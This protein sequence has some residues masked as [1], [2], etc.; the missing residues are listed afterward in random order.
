M[1]LPPSYDT[2]FYPANI[3]FFQEQSNGSSPSNIIDAR[4]VNKLQNVLAAVE[5]HTQYCTET[6]ISTG[7]TVYFT[8]FQQQLP[9]D[10]P[11]TYMKMSVSIPPGIASSDF[12]GNPFNRANPVFA[13]AVGYRIVGGNRVYFPVHCGVNVL[14]ENNNYTCIVVAGKQS[15]WKAGDWVEGALLVCKT[16]EEEELSP[17]L[18]DMIWWFKADSLTLN[19][20]DS[21]AS[22]TD[23][24]SFGNDMQFPGT[25]GG[26]QP[27]F[28]TGE[29]N[30]LPVVR[31]VA[32]NQGDIA[33]PNFS[34]KLEDKS[35]TFYWVGNY[36]NVQSGQGIVLYNYTTTSSD[37]IRLAMSF[38]IGGTNGVGWEYDVG[39]GTVDVNPAAGASGLQILTWV[40]DKTA[41]SGYVYRDGV[42][43]GLSAN[44]GGVGAGNGFDFGQDFIEFFAV[45][46]GSQTMVGDTGEIIAYQAAHDA[47]TVAETVAYLSDKWGV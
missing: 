6:A 38:D 45:A 22:W 47:A 29:I 35:F 41:G 20:G 3:D 42:Q 40:F 9:N 5:T 33:F 32:G 31:T 27:T 7:H 12:G 11:G 17:P 10:Q 26:T 34:P 14:Q 21:I 4:L 13:T 19:D 28:Q 24:S 2:I 30:S 36:N 37:A 8:G 1:P 16:H 44:V 23:S 18:T 39:A 46:G 15:Q 25:N 43:V